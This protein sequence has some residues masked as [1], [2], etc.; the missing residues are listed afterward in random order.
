[1]S[2]FK[3]GDRVRCISCSYSDAVEVGMI[4]EVVSIYKGTHSYVVGVKWDN[5]YL[6]H[7]CNGT[8]KDGES[9]YYVTGDE[10]EIIEEQGCCLDLIY[11]A[12]L[13]KN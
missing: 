1:M 13:V 12:Q 11:D 3:I 10:I 5:F 8:I 7:N 9:G 2:K 4:G 6:G